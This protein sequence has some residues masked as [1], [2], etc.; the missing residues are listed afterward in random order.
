MSARRPADAFGLTSLCAI[1]VM[2]GNKK[3]ETQRT[4]YQGGFDANAQRCSPLLRADRC[5]SDNGYRGFRR[6]PGE[7]NQDRRDLRLDRS[8][9]WRRL[10]A[11]YIGAKIMLDRYSKTGVEGYKVEA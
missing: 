6:S 10:G 1:N 8:V 2:G 4:I 5:Y 11:Q 3:Q 9:G 7:E